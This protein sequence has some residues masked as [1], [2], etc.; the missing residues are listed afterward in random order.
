MKLKAFNFVLLQDTGE[1]MNIP[2]ETNPALTIEENAQN[3]L[4]HYNSG[5]EGDVHTSFRIEIAEPTRII[6]TG[7]T[8]AEGYTER[9][10][11]SILAA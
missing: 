4:N 7:T 11:I 2:L 9:S 3:I 10:I 6:I 5:E 8:L 1:T